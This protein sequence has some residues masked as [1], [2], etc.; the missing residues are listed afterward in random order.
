MKEKEL[1]LF[2]DAVLQE[3]TPATKVHQN[4]HAI[5]IKSML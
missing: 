3:D 5:E 1:V 4:H 2:F